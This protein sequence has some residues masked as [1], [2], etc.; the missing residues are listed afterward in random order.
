METIC[1][2]ATEHYM[3]A[4]HIYS[5]ALPMNDCKLETGVYMSVIYFIWTLLINLLG[6]FLRDSNFQACP[7]SPG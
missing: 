6:F 3:T 7:K 5:I 4:C 1:S 2:H